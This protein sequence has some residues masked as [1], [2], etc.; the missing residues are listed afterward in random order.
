MEIA[1]CPVAA[2]LDYLVERGG[3]PGPLLHFRDEK[4][5]TRARFVEKP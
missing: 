3:G 5:L 1:V 4:P 2:M